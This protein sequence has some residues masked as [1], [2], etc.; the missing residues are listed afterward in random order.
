M[1]QKFFFYHIR[2]EASPW[3]VCLPNTET[4][5]VKTCGCLI[6]E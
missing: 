2:R 1:I 3:E 6:R 4:S 5:V